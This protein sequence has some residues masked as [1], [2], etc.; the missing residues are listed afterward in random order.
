MWEDVRVICHSEYLKT[1]IAPTR[2]SR[3]IIF[4][5]GGILFC[6]A[7]SFIKFKRVS[8]AIQ[9]QRTETFQQSEND[10]TIANSFEPLFSFLIQFSIAQ[11]NDEV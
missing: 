1:L 3:L 11:Y 8:P 5:K 6:F 4:Y 10:S 9:K 2:P 7:K